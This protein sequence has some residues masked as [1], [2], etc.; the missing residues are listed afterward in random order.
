M[1]AIEPNHD[2][3]PSWLLSPVERVYNLVTFSPLPSLKTPPGRIVI[4]T[5]C[6][7][8][9]EVVIGDRGTVHEKIVNI[10]ALLRSFIVERVRHTVAAHL[11]RASRNE[12]HLV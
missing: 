12:E 10:N 7:K 2:P 8:L 1:H 6:N 5:G 11:E 9:P 3:A 4:A